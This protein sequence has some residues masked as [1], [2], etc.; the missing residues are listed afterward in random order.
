MRKWTNFKAGLFFLLLAAMGSAQARFVSVD[1]VQA[2]AN[3][4]QNFNRYHYANNN[5]YKFTDLDGRQAAERFVEQHRRDMEAGN[6][7][8]YEPFLKPAA[9]VTGAMLLGPV[10]LAAAANPVTATAIG[11]GVADLAMGDALGGASIA[12]GGTA[13][14]RVVDNIELSS[15]KDAGR[16]L[17]SPNGDSVKRFLNNLPD[18][19]ALAQKFSGKFGEQHVVEGIAPRKVIDASS[20][21]PFSDVPG[22]LMNSIGVPNEQLPNIKCV[23]RVDGC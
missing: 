22:R 21:T 15:I 2:N 7:K 14:F 6:G 9:V 5:P 23:G 4:G 19:K 17:P 18:A 10:G 20:I 1:P 12:A 8:V 3:N 13:L 11:T 16:F